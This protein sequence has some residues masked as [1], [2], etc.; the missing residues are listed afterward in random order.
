MPSPYSSI[1]ASKAKWGCDLK[2]SGL[3]KNQRKV[4]DYEILRV[5]KSHER[6]REMS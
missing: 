6:L 5:V 4:V 3:G 2:I 1:D